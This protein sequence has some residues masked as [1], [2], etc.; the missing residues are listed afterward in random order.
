MAKSDDKDFKAFIFLL[1]LL[2]IAVLY[3]DHNNHVNFL[4]LYLIL[5][6]TSF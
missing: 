6:K 2:N 5:L 3:I 4:P 1:E